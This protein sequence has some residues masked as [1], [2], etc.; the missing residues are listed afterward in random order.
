MSNSIKPMIS[1]IVVNYHVKKELF[2]C[3]S[4]VIAS[5]SKIAY[6]IIVV[7]NDEVKS[8]KKDLKKKYPQVTYVPNENKGFGQGNNVG[9]KSA[10]GDY[11]FFLN[12]DTEIFPHALD[13]LL[14]SLKQDKK[15]G[16]VAP[17]L[18]DKD[19]KPYQQGT[20]ELTPTTGIVA[21]SLINKIFPNNSLS[22]KYFLNE[23]D[24]KSI[25]EVDVVPGT[26][27]MMKRS[28]FEELGG[29]DEKFF[30][31]FEEFDLCRR[32]KELGLTLFIIP[33]AKV[34]H[35]WGASTKTRSDINQ[36]Y[37]QSRFYYFKKHFGLFVAL[38]TE[39]V[40]RI[41]KYTILVTLFAALGFFLRS[42][43]ID[44]TMPFIGDQ[45]WFY[46]SAR[47]MII[48]NT[49]PLVGIAS[50]HPWLHQGALWTYLLGGWLWFFQ[51]NPISGAYL[52]I[53]LDSLAVI[54]FYNVAASLFSRRAGVIVAALY[55]TSPLI[56]FNA[57]MPYHTSPIPLVT[58]IFL[59]VLFQWVNGKKNYFPLVIMTLAILYNLEIAT[60]V[61]T[62]LTAI[63]FVYG[64]IKRKQWVWELFNRKTFM[65]TIV[66]F[67]MV[68]LPMLVYDSSHG[69][70][71]TLGF[72][73]WIG[74][75]VLVLFGYPQLN[76]T[77]LISWS[78]MFSFAGE[79]YTKLLFP[80]SWIVAGIIFCG[81]LGYLFT[82]RT[83]NFVLLSLLTII[84][85]LGLF[86]VKT[87]SEAY[88]PMLFPSLL[89]GVAVFFDML[90]KD[91]RLKR[92]I[93]FLL[94][95]IVVANSYYLF[96]NVINSPDSFT[97]R[98][99]AAKEIVSQANN[100][101]YNIKGTG[102]GS[103]FKSF[104][105]NYHYLTWWLGHEPST[106]V[107]KNQFIITEKRDKIE[108]KQQ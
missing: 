42:F 38:F 35:H 63:V 83:S 60:F 102:S 86:A 20:R 43:R 93:L 59:Y 47:D 67:L 107:Q 96:S 84:P 70:P 77:P 15:R 14:S 51:W 54:F 55:A 36:I 97:Q 92:H 85:L 89:L 50:S 75:K 78:T 8:I 21:L 46:L 104:T 41:G 10:K 3:I 31:Y 48:N 7:D 16:V 74:Y 25:K 101:E 53:L 65:W 45:G 9:S 108:V 26:A 58:I 12:P 62:I 68:M 40:M 94:S 11:L 22:K 66:S 82:K 105:M 79:Q 71:Q 18:L 95:I 87:P 39:S 24:R 73:A 27:F 49:I 33:N 76:P 64:L 23:W 99:A 61:L 30:L 57:R 88:L 28:L 13:N 52:S 98:F 5:K 106:T 44:Q 80:N 34:F 72:I 17:L 100:T 2:A 19:K 4:S 69:Y 37:L 32:V 81:S 91:R 103:Q 56:I 1:L 6:E 29:F 90:M